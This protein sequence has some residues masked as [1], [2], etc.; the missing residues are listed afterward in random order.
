LTVAK[1]SRRRFEREDIWL[2][3]LVFTPVLS[4]IVAQQLSFLMTRSMCNAGGRWTL[5]VVMGMALLATAAAGAAS[6]TRWQ[7]L[8]SKTSASR[9]RMYRRF[10]ALGGVLMASL[11]GVSIV[12]LMIPATLQRLCD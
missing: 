7:A 9:I 12:A 3:L 8:A 11:C 2:W 4:W 10:L 6:W 1:A 5:Y